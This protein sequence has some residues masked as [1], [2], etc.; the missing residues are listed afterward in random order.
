MVF[1]CLCLSPPSAWGSRRAVLPPS[2]CKL[3]EDRVSCILCPSPWKFQSLVREIGSWVIS[4]EGAKLLVLGKV[5]HASSGSQ[6]WLEALH[7]VD[8]CER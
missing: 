2:D 8:P 1:L 6:A 3:V 4:A 7:Q 5:G